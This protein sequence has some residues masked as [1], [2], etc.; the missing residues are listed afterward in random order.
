[1]ARRP[2][3]AAIQPVS[4]S[5]AQRE[6]RTAELIGFLVGL[7]VFVLIAKTVVFMF[8]TPAV[9]LAVLPLETQGAAV[10]PSQKA[11]VLAETMSEMM[12]CGA[13]AGVVRYSVSSFGPLLAGVSMRPRKWWGKLDGAT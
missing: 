4:L 12:N 7:S 8:M 6:V 1:V 5:N 9:V 13:F 10:D 3:D 2:G 11:R